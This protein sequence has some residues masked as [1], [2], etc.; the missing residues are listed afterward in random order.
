[1][2]Y[3]VELRYDRTRASVADRESLVVAL[4]HLLASPHAGRIFNKLLAPVAD[5]SPPVPST[6]G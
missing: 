1:M 6:S 3:P 5:A 4:Q 2:G